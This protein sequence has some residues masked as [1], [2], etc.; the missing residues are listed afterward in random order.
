MKM[1]L[2]Q[3]IRPKRRYIDVPPDCGECFVCKLDIEEN[4]K[5]KNFSE[6]NVVI[7]ECDSNKSK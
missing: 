2:H 7:F 5:C 3:F 4:K 1:C 6:I